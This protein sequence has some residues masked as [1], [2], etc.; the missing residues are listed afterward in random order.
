M[1]LPHWLTYQNSKVL[2]GSPGDLKIYI[3]IGLVVEIKEKVE[4]LNISLIKRTKKMLIG[5]YSL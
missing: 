1:H 5:G 2:P 3:H 4:K